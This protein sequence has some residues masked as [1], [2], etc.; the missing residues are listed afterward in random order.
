MAPV[1]NFSLTQV[2]AVTFYRIYVMMDLMVPPKCL[3]QNQTSADRYFPAREQQLSA[4]TVA[5]TGKVTVPA[6][7]LGGSIR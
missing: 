6:G 1:R 5:E 4:S 2:E 3:L 7:C